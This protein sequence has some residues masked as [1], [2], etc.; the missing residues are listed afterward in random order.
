M[1]SPLYVSV[2]DTATNPARSGIQMVVRSLVGALGRMARDRARLVVWHP[3]TDSLR[4][5]P[6]D[7]SVGLGGENLR[8]DAPVRLREWIGEPRP[9]LAGARPDRLPLHFHPRHRQELPGAWLLLPEL[10][11]RS[12]NA[13]KFIAYAHR[14]G[15]RV[16]AIFHDA[17]PIEHPE[18]APPGLTDL[19]REYMRGLATCDLLLATSETSAASWH[20]FIREEKLA[21]IP[22][23]I[24][25]LASEIPG[26]PRVLQARPVAD[27]PVR[28]L[29]VS[30]AEP[31]KNH[32]T[33][34]A[35]L[36]L[37][38]TEYGRLP[39]EIDLVGAPYAGAEA[40]A[41]ALEQAGRRHPGR[42]RWHRR[43]D[44][45]Q[46]R[47]LYLG[48]DFTVYPSL[49]EGFGMPVMES[50]WFARPCVCANFS[51]MAE[52]A[53]GGGCLTVDVRS[54][55]ALA[56]AIK[57]LINDPALRARLAEAATTRP[58]KTWDDYAERILGALDAA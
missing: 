16:A 27:D 52:N 4:S 9:W 21:P 11:Y 31:R 46:L 56:G 32:Q 10:I 17:I 30:T 25:R 43:A 33:L 40:L 58:L 1:P 50:L 53:A 39:L 13:G 54:P 41:T 7:V 3:P 37:L 6:P 5:M 55:S 36:D 19:H 34:L 48:C 15:M 38:A 12:G 29:C 28:A 20:A 45:A 26:A 51:I 42:F 2:T 14:Q 8:D 57:L 22:L 23:K 18:F 24:I 44:T 49:V 35:A 47:E